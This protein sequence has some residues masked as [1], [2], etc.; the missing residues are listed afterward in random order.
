MVRVDFT[1][2][3]SR[4]ID[5]ESLSVEGSNLREV[6]IAVCTANTQL[7]SYLLDDQDRLRKHVT[8][9][10]DNVQIKDRIQLSDPVS[11]SS[12]VYITQALS[13]G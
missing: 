13:G 5:C 8:V 1:P 4:H 2:N 6:I 9:F 7:K 3:L 10:I 11:Q 12:S